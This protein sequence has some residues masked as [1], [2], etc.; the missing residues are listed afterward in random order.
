MKLGFDIFRRLDDGSPLR[1]AQVHSLAE[2]R[3]KV[4]ALRKRSPG[5]YF[6]RDGN[7]PVDSGGRAREL[8]GKFRASL[9]GEAED[10]RAIKEYAPGKPR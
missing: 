5:Q 4:E 1:L 2:A 9:A 10:L 3:A 7:R 8:P 6:V